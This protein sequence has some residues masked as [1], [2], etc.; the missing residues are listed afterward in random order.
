MTALVDNTE[1]IAVSDRSGPPWSDPFASDRYVTFGTHAGISLWDGESRQLYSAWPYGNAD[2]A[3]GSVDGAATD[4]G[5]LVW[6]GYVEVD[7]EIENLIE[8]VPLSSLE[9]PF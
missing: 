4:G 6:S 9:M 1:A 3:H 5:W 8:G 2:P 7:G